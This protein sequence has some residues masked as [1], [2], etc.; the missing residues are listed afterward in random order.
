[1]TMDEKVPPLKTDQQAEEFL[2]Q[3]LSGLD[4]LRFKPV[5]FEIESED[6]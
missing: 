6:E 2:A 4:F 1:M 3:D 5:W